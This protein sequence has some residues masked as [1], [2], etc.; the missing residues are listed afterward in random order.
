MPLMY[1]APSLRGFGMTVLGNGLWDTI[2]TANVSSLP[3][4]VGAA[5]LVDRWMFK[6]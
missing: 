5:I 4:V 2:I 1:L 6:Q 3:E